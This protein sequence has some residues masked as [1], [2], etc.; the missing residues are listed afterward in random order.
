MKREKGRRTYA[1]IMTKNTIVWALETA[2]PAYFRKIKEAAP[3]ILPKPFCKLI[4]N[5]FK[6]FD[7]AN[8]YAEQLTEAF[9][10]CEIQFTPVELTDVEDTEDLNIASISVDDYKEAT[11]YLFANDTELWT[12]AT[13]KLRELG[14]RAGIE[15]AWALQSA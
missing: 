10:F 8:A 13:L 9:G 11:G 12:T 3:D 4:R 14:E 15:P 2:D 6:D 1:V 5:S 7:E